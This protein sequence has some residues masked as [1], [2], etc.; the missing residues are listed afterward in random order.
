MI[1]SLVL[2]AASARWRLG[3]TVFKMIGGIIHWKEASPGEI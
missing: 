1:V 2:I 3:M